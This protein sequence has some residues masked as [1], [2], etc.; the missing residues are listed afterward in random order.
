MYYKHYIGVNKSLSQ[1]LPMEIHSGGFFCK[2]NKESI[3]AAIMRMEI[4]EVI[5]NKYVEI[6]LAKLYTHR[7]NL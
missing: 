7:I 2:Y 5:K 1:H 4:A 3:I 6:V